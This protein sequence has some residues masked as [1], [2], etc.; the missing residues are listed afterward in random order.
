MTVACVSMIALRFATFSMPN[1]PAPRIMK[2]VSK[3]ADGPW[4]MLSVS[5][6]MP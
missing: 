2:W 5:T 3:V 6:P 4:S 1:S